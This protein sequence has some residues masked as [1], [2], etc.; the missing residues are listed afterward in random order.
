ML[1]KARL[2]PCY[3]NLFGLYGVESVQDLLDVG[4][5]EDQMA[6]F[7]DDLETLVQGNGFLAEADLNGH[8]KQLKYLGRELEHGKLPVFKFNLLDRKKL[9]SL[10]VLAVQE[11]EREKD[12]LHSE[13]L[14]P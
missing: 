12:C 13:D 3:G 1:L 10:S 6:A 14:Q 2:K 9:I 8:A 7:V 11:K 5:T 4:T